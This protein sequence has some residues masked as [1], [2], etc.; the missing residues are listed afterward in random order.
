MDE[1]NNIILDG[2]QSEDL[3]KIRSGAGDKKTSGVDAEK[4]LNGVY[5]NNYRIRLDHQILTDHGICYPQALYNDL[6]YKRYEA[7]VG[8]KTTETLIDSF[9]MLVSKGVGML[10]SIDDV[11][12]LQKDLKNDYTINQELSSIA[13][14]LSLRCGRMLAVANADL[15]TTKHIVF[16]ESDTAREPDIVERA[17]K[18]REKKLEKELEKKETMCT[19]AEIAKVIH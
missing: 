15:I 18:G 7:Y 5:K 9:L 8:I 11:K 16:K 13:G 1:R 12:K 6:F 19:Q 3:C 4:K 2:I 14:S 10:V 17:N